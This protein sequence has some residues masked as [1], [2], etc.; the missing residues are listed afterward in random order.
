[1]VKE[2]LAADMEAV[3]AEA[4]A[5]V[6]H[7]VPQELQDLQEEEVSED[8]EVVADTVEAPDVVVLQ[9]PPVSK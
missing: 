2:E 5:V 4:A 9:E 8:K 7:Q 6:E 3:A 1:V